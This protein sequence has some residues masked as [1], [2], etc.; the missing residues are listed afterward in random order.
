[1]HY[2]KLSKDSPSLYSHLRRHFSP[3]ELELGESI[4]SLCFNHSGPEFPEVSREPGM[5]FNP[6]PA[7]V[8]EI[9]LKEAGIKDI[10]LA[11]SAMLSL[12]PENKRTD[13]QG[14]FQTSPAVDLAIA[15]DDLRHFHMR[16]D[17]LLTA[18]GNERFKAVLSQPIAQELSGLH[19]KVSLAYSR[20][21]KNVGQNS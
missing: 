10:K 19:A 20:L 6:R 14:I 1:M 21:L 17:R 18:E 15:L 4:Y 12:V 5:S 8:A 11:Y 7:R 9:I 3:A 16:K 13:F 2:G